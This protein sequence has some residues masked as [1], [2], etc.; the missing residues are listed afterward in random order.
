MKKLILVACLVLFGAA[1]ARAQVAS[2]ECNPALWTRVYSRYRFATP[3]NSQN[4]VEPPHRC[5]Q[6]RGRIERV[7]PVGEEA[8]G[9]IHI[10]I[11]PDN[12]GVLRPGQTFLVAEIVC[13]DNTPAIGPARV[14]CR[15]YQNSP[16][17]SYGRVGRFRKNQHV[18]V[19]GELVVDYL[20]LRSGWVEIH[21]VTRIDPI[22]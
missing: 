5:V 7:Y 11:V 19:V 4:K 14:A 10:S 15:G 13:A 21:P 16:L 3:V 12:S 22:Q 18:E 17:L 6:I 20:H 8:D 9:D 2:H 1:A